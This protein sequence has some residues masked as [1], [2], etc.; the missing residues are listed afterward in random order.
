MSKYNQVVSATPITCKKRHLIYKM[1]VQLY[2]VPYPIWRVILI[3]GNDT[4]S[5]L[6]TVA[7]KCMGWD[8]SHLF[9]I[10][11]KKATNKSRTPTALRG[12]DIE[13]MR[14]SEVFDFNTT[15]ELTYDMGDN[16][17]HEIKVLDILPDANVRAPFC[18]RAKGI[19]PPEDVG[20]G[21]EYARKLRIFEQPSHPDYDEIQEWLGADFDPNMLVDIN[22][23]NKRLG[24]K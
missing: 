20:G 16:W 15:G 19:C 4:I 10:E 7:L 6:Q 1:K 21:Y 22:R 18:L 9:E 8:F 13:C 24:Y 11:I 17:I 23:I 3:N 14:I 5:T 12:D 2:Q